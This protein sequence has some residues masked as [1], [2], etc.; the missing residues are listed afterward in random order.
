MPKIGDIIDFP[1]YYDAGNLKKLKTPKYV[2]KL[3]LS[4]EFDEKM[5]TLLDSY[6]TVYVWDAASNQRHSWVFTLR[7]LKD[8]KLVVETS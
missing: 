5:P 8:M 3:I 1:C 7:A 4:I 2:R 6:N